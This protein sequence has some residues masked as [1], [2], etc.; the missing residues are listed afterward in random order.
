MDGINYFNVA[1]FQLESALIYKISG[2]NFPTGHSKFMSV[3]ETLY[4][5]KQ[6]KM[7]KIKPKGRSEIQI[8]NWAKAVFQRYA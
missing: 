2:V 8:S 4:K 3:K 6:F 5:K 1:Y 7:L